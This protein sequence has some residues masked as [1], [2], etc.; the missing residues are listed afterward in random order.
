[1]RAGKDARGLKSFQAVSEEWFQRHVMKK[2]LRSAAH[3]KNC[4]DHHILP[5]WRDR[6][7]EGIR[8]HDVAKLMDEVED[9]SGK[10]S[11]DYV[12]K[13]TTGI[14]NWY[15]ARHEDYKTPIAKGMRRSSRKENARARILNDDELRAV[16]K[17]AEA[18]GSFGAFIRILLLTGQ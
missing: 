15:L 7:F 16:W 12:L 3:L 2:E 6:D 10:N 13:I 9:A 8:R 18:N 4:L 5:A 14:C 17:A 1:I 11:A